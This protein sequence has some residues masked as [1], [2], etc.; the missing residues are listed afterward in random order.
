MSASYAVDERHYVP[1]SLAATNLFFKL[2]YGSLD[3]LQLVL[4]HS[5]DIFPAFCPFVILD[6]DTVFVGLDADLQ[7]VGDVIRE[8]FE[9]GG[10]SVGDGLSGEGVGGETRVRDEAVD[11]CLERTCD[12]VGS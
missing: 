7:L 6:F 11:V 3:D 12:N 2:L 4:E 1:D 10:G 5:C 8:V 9:D